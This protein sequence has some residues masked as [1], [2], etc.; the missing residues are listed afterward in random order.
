MKLSATYKGF[1]TGILMVLLSLGIYKLRG[2]FENNLQYITYAVY[3]GGI[4]WTL[5][6][7]HRRTGATRSFKNYFTEGFKCFIVVTFVMVLFTYIFSVLNPGLK[8]Q[9]AANYRADLVSKKNYTGPEIDAMVQKA[10][11][12]FNVMLTS[13]AIFGYILIGSL[14][15]LVTSIFL[16]QRKLPDYR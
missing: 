11:E 2:S 4:V 13:M 14:V 8:E 15:T 9:M 10:R 3:V 12:Y 6:S 16:A 7:F 5:V 1:I